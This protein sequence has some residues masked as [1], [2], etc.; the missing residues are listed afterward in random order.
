MPNDVKRYDMLVREDDAPLPEMERAD[1]GDFVRFADYDAIAKR[2]A[3]YDALAA[4]AAHIN[5]TK[6][7]NADLP[8]L[9]EDVRRIMRTL[10][11]LAP[12][13]SDA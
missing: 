12:E 7:R 1:D 3:R 10:G 5:R 4:E 6:Y 2:L 8:Q 9:T 11:A 13:V